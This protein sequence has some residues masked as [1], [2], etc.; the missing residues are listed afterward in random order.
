MWQT[1]IKFKQTFNYDFLMHILLFLHYRSLK[2]E[3]KTHPMKLGHFFCCFLLSLFIT[4][5]IL[6]SYISTEI[7]HRL[8][9]KLDLGKTFLICFSSNIW[10]QK[11][12]FEHSHGI[13]FKQCRY[14]FIVSDTFLFCNKTFLFIFSEYAD[15]QTKDKIEIVIL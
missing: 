13:F 5:K 3:R 9:L 2:W 1:S 6:D 4:C 10:D 15:E 8:D 7:F 12:Y 11:N 14:P